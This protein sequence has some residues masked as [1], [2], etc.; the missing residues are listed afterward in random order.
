MRIWSNAIW[1]LWHFFSIPLLART[2]FTPFQR[3]QDAPVKGF[4]PEAFFE[5]II[6]NILM[7]VVGMF[8][9]IC[10]LVVGFSLLLVSIIFGSLFFIA[11]LAAPLLSVFMFGAGL[12]LLVS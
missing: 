2:F 4:D 1:F 12:V 8:V 9:R 5:S 6:V 3:I 11:W 7:R 10:V